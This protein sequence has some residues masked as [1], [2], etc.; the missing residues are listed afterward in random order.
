[1]ISFIS[2][3]YGAY[4]NQLFKK[5]LLFDGVQS[6]FQCILINRRKLLSEF[7]MNLVHYLCSSGVAFTSER[8][9]LGAHA[10]TIGGIVGSFHQAISLQAIH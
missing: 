4:M 3:V 6:A 7:D 10:S 9:H 1:M 5:K 2:V 8:R